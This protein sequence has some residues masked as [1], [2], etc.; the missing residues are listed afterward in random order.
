MIQESLWLKVLW[1]L[2]EILLS[3]HLRMDIRS[4]MFVYDSLRMFHVRYERLDKYVVPLKQYAKHDSTREFNQIFFRY[5]TEQILLVHKTFQNLLYLD[6]KIP[7]YNLDPF[8]LLLIFS[9]MNMN[10]SRR[11]ILHPSSDLVK[12]VLQMY[13]M[14][15]REHSPSIE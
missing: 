3:L 8:F 4:L 13:R 10:N 9:V 14:C 1:S 11:E 7:M 6:N 5:S 12:F 2:E 15:L